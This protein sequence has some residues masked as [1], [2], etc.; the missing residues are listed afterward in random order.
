MNGRN[1]IKFCGKVKE[2]VAVVSGKSYE[3]GS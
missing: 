1:Y 3:V 2:K